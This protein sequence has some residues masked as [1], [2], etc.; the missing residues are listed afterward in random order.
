M[1]YADILKILEATQADKLSPYSIIF[2]SEGG[3]EKVYVT[4]P[5][6]FRELYTSLH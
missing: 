6:K 3:S 5:K 2:K 4:L 1:A